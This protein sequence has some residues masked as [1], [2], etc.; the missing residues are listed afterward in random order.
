MR[1]A[2]FDLDNTLISGDSDHAWGE[3]LIRVGAVDEERYRRAN[4][5]YLRSYE[6]GTLDIDDYLSFSLQPLAQH[7]RK[8]LEA[9]RRDFMAEVIEPM[10]LPKAE[11]L[12][13]HHREAGDFLMIITATNRF[14]TAPIAERFK[15]DELIAIEVEERDGAYTGRVA[16]VPS[17]QRG[18]VTRL[19]AWLA[20]HPEIEREGCWFYSDSRNDLPLLE[21]VDRPV[22]VDPDPMLKIEAERRGWT[23][24]SL[25]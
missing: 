19:E 14:V 2:I 6:A 9:W 17:F 1:L 22:A 4:D 24:M 10:V 16:G 7:P 8:L 12:L 13:D 21:Q 20:E 11:A 15:V 18:K 3:Y 23:V 5:E 25:R